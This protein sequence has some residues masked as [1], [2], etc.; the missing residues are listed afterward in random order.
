MR[1]LTWRR[2]QVVTF[3]AT[4]VICDGKVCVG[5]NIDGTSFSI[6]IDDLVSVLPVGTNYRVTFHRYVYEDLGQPGP[7]ITIDPKFLGLKKVIVNKK[8]MFV[9]KSYFKLSNSKE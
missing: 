7:S 3:T 9:N 1:T 6:I 4:K 5:K 2:D 8:P